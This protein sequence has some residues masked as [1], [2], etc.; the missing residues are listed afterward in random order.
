MRDEQRRRA[1]AAPR[2][3]ALRRAPR[4]EVARALRDDVERHQRVRAAAVLG[5]LAAERRR[6]VGA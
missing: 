3:L 5:A 6:R 2:R 1:A 4:L